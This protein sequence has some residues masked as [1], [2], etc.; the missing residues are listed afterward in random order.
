M[1]LGLQGSP[2]DRIAIY[3][4]LLVGLALNIFSPTTMTDPAIFTFLGAQA[5]I[6]NIVLQ[7]GLVPLHT[8]EVSDYVVC[9]HTAEV[10]VFCNSE[11]LC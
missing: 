3:M 7:W 6:A 10:C 5:N 1:L 4:L 2:D 8:T 9:F 11:D